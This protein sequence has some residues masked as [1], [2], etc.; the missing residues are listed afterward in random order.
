MVCDCVGIKTVETDLLFGKI[1]LAEESRL[2]LALLTMVLHLFHLNFS[3]NFFSLCQ[4][5]TF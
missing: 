2:G 5:S 3:S 4:S 1:W